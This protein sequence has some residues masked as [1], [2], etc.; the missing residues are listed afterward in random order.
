MNID[1][2]I[3]LSLTLAITAALTGQLPKVVKEMRIAQLKVL[4]ESQSSKWGM[5]MLLPTSRK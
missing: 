5:P 3:K 1:G 4:K 2:L